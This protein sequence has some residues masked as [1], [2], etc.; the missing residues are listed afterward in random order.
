VAAVAALPVLRVLLSAAF[1]KVVVPSGVLSS[2]LFLLALPLS[3]I[4]LYALAT[5]SA[6]VPDAPVTHAWLRPP[7]AYLTAGLVLF[8]VAGLA[9]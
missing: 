3:A 9:V 4:G 6:R 8:V 1:G 7:L 2:V 5:G